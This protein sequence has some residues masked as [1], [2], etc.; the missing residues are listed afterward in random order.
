M[1][2]R[3]GQGKKRNI[4]SN[5]DTNS[6]SVNGTERHENFHSKT[7]KRKNKKTNNEK[8]ENKIKNEKLKK[9][10]RKTKCICFQK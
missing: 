3:Y 5:I 4:L 6:F 8:N 2:R 10:K 7:K 1:Q 9:E